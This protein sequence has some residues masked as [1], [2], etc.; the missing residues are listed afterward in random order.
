[1]REAADAAADFEARV[2]KRAAEKKKE[3]EG[4]APAAPAGAGEIVGEAPP[5]SDGDEAPPP[6]PPPEGHV[7][8]FDPNQPDPRAEGD[9]AA[10]AADAPAQR[11]WGE[12]F[13][14]LTEKTTTAVGEWGKAASEKAKTTVDAVKE[15]D[16]A[17]CAQFGAILVRRRA[18]PLLSRRPL[19]TTHAGT[20]RRR[21][22]A[23]AR[24]RKRRR[25]WAAARRRR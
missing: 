7:G 21:V 3:K 17:G 24:S 15:A 22:S 13:K 5:P 18:I 19:A 9:E 14:G 10:A 4:K 1:M 25:R 16:W 12:W 23:R 6:P 2:A 20:R 11:T 8:V